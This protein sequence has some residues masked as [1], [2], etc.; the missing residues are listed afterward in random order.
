MAEQRFSNIEK[1]VW[2]TMQHTYTTILK[3]I[4][5]HH[6]TL[7]LLYEKVKRM[8]AI[9]LKEKDLHVLSLT[10]TTD[11]AAEG[12][13]SAATTATYPKMNMFDEMLNH[14]MELANIAEEKYKAYGLFGYRGSSFHEETEN[15]ALEN[16]DKKNQ[17]EVNG[18]EVKHVDA[19]ETQT[20]PTAATTDNNEDE[21]D[22]IILSS[23]ALIAKK[24]NV[25]PPLVVV[26]DVIHDGS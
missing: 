1:K 19:Q 22:K 11:A 7:K 20:S 23:N 18:V 21:D 14:R 26:N 2:I 15:V 12:E 9:D 5:T 13:A 25:E 16:V 4:H 24:A 17:V 10:A 6:Q 8:D 3:Q